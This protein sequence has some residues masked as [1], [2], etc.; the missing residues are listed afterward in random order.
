MTPDEDTSTPGAHPTQALH[1]VMDWFLDDTIRQ[2]PEELRRAH[3]AVA[4]ALGLTLIDLLLLL[5]TPWGAPV[6]YG[7]L[8]LPRPAIAG[9]IASVPIH[10]SIAY[11]IKRTQ[12][13]ASAAVLLPISLLVLV[14]YLAFFS[15][16]PTGPITWWLV[17]VP[18]FG[19]FLSG[20][21][22]ALYS[23]AGV[24]VVLGVL[25]GFDFAGLTPP[26]PANHA[27]GA[28]ERS[29]L[30]LLGFVAFVAWYYERSR[31]ERQTV[32][33]QT[34]ANLEETHQALRLSERHLVQVTENL[35]Q[36]IWMYDPALHRVLYVNRAWE[37]IWGRSRTDLEADPRSWL[38]AV[39]SEDRENLPATPAWGAHDRDFSYRIQTPNG[40]LRWIRH[41]V[42]LVGDDHGPGARVIHIAANTTQR[43]EAEELRDRFVEA[44]IR[45]QEL[46]RQHLAR[47][48]HD[49]T[50][51]SLTALL[52]GLRTLEQ[53][54]DAPEPLHLVAQ[55]RDH[56]RGIVGD[57]GRL[58]RGLH[59]TALN[60]LGLVAAIRRL[61]D[62][63]RETHGLKVNVIVSGQEGEGALPQ[64][65]KLT[66]Y[67]I[68]QEAMTNAVKHARANALDV[69]LH[70]DD[71]G[72]HLRV[73]D[74][75]RG[76][77]PR[78]IVATD[79]SGS[80]LGLQSM[81]ERAALLRGEV[82]IEAA[83]G[84]GTTVIAD[85][86]IREPTEFLL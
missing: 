4:S 39:V 14:A 77:T 61:G 71:F 82:V 8:P 72:V 64:T 57:I 80:G 50:G 78:A 59:P 7:S 70:I 83:P 26:S 74:D 32:I 24:A 18:L 53:H 84:H 44:V 43:R 21:R 17:A 23:A 42:R 34:Y 13:V 56:L 46:E 69:S 86:P 52:V 41:A 75:G 9:L 60:E 81:R 37:L 33:S 79:T 15:G 45:V 55:L 35:G 16:G 48:L 65:V 20:P 66:V 51:Q 29:Q 22:G 19:A 1:F 28:A 54:L 12:R 3:L 68:A 85:L 38:D 10:I 6:W 47:E 73:E 30:T 67:R 5:F 62:D 40:D 49:Q 27:H 63:A 76:F 58:S 25:W 36:A 31:V 11:T 2:D